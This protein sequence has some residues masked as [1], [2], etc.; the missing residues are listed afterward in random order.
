M[1]KLFTLLIVT[2]LAIYTSHAN[3]YDLI[4][5]T[6]KQQI[7]DIDN[8]SKTFLN[9]QFQITMSDQKAKNQFKLLL[10]KNGC[11]SGIADDFELQTY[12]KTTNKPIKSND[13]N[14]GSDLVSS[15]WDF[16]KQNNNS[17]CTENCIAD[18][19]KS[20]RWNYSNFSSECRKA[21][22]IKEQIDS[23]NTSVKKVIRATEKANPYG[24]KVKAKGY[25]V[26]LKQFLIF[27]GTAAVEEIIS[28]GAE[29][30][31]EH[32]TGRDDNNNEAANA[33]ITQLQE[34]LTALNITKHQ[35]E[36]KK[37]GVLAEY[38]N[39]GS[40]LEKEYISKEEHDK[41]SIE[42]G[43]K[44]NTLEAEDESITAKINDTNDKI[45]KLQDDEAGTNENFIVGHEEE[46]E[47]NF[48]QLLSET[49]K[50]CSKNNGQ[51]PIIINNQVM[52]DSTIVSY[53]SDYSPETGQCDL[54]GLEKEIR[55]SMSTP[56]NFGTFGDNNLAAIG[57]E[58]KM[59]LQRVESSITQLVNKGLTL[60]QAAIRNGIEDG[61]KG[62]CALYPSSSICQSI[63]ATNNEIDKFVKSYGIHESEA[64]DKVLKETLS[65][66]GYIM[67]KKAKQILGDQ[68]K[69]GSKARY[70]KI[71]DLY[72][73]C[74]NTPSLHEC[75]ESKF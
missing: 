53:R 19:L 74:Y 52:K 45:K 22:L 25:G 66:K 37:D 20:L 38:Q 23:G 6:S 7:E 62:F 5:Q 50:Q 43:D 51:T 12:S 73:E 42:I 26:L 40:N 27:V 56:G 9:H 15:M 59:K 55:S 28:Q 29:V 63:E 36:V 16:I 31:L 32:A 48:E 34:E 47:R 3:A 33:E 68:V 35:I 71:N 14:K 75:L 1:I 13:H 72:K 4:N 57:F 60:D 2:V 10:E 21:M 65:P 61:I 39:N 41:K 17:E 46:V 8:L 64:L 24:P 11:D 30:A 58:R 70:D 67:H 18:D 49:V 54:D 44:Y 69:N